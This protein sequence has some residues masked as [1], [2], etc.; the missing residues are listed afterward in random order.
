M[1]FRDDVYFDG[2]YK[3]SRER[4]QD[5]S[6]RN[7]RPRFVRGRGRINSRIDSCQGEWKSDREFTGEFYNGPSHFR[8]SRHRFVSAVHDSESEYNN[9]AHDGSFVG[10]NRFGRKP[11]NE[12]GPV[13]RH[14]MRRRS[15]GVREMQMGQRYPRNMS[16]SRCSGDDGSEFVGM[17]HGE[18]FIRGYP[19]D[20]SEPMF[21]RSQPFERGDG[22]FTRGARNFIQRRGPPRIHSKS[23]TRSRTRSP[24]PWS[25]PRRRTPRGSPDGYNGNPELA[26][27]RRVD[28]MRSPD[29]NLFSGERRGVRRHVSPLYMSRPY[30]D[31]RDFDS[32]RGRGHPRPGISNRGTSGRILFR[33]RR[34]DGVD[35]QDRADNDEYFGGPMHSGRQFELN[36]E[37]NGDER[38]RYERRGPVRSFRPPYN[39]S[40]GENFDLDAE[41]GP[42]TYRFCPTDSEFP[43][44]NNLRERDFDRRMKNRPANMPPRRT[45]NIDEQETNYRNSGPEVWSDDS[46]DDISRMKR[47]RF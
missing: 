21:S 6:P 19:E 32:G 24:G 28:R 16:P 25:S 43:E 26:H 11:L 38:R 2:P 41:D 12:E 10:N 7:S 29:G 27:R 31:T 36:G 8:G 35:P 13:G 30:N 40:V 20:T 15:P 37:G 3:F 22:R 47:K 23:P 45:R 9:V 42:R 1:I 46:F 17:R 44:R 4:H 33:N 5:I 18:K 34:F 39:G 14:I